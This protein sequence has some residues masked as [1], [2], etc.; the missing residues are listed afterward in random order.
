MLLQTL[1]LPAHRRKSTTSCSDRPPL[2][3]RSRGLGPGRPPFTRSVPQQPTWGHRAEKSNSSSFSGGRLRDHRPAS[4]RLHQPTPRTTGVPAGGLCL[5]PPHPGPAATAPS[6]QAGGRARLWAGSGSPTWTEPQSGW[7]AQCSSRE[8]QQQRSSPSSSR[9]SI[10]PGRADGGAG[11]GRPGEG[12][13]RAGS[14]GVGSHPSPERDCPN[15]NSGGE[16]G[17]EGG[18]EGGGREAGR[19]AG[20]E[21]KG[22][23]GKP[24]AQQV[25]APSAG[26]HASTPALP[27]SLPARP[28]GCPSPGCSAGR[29]RQPARAGGPRPALTAEPGAPSHPGGRVSGRK[30]LEPAAG[31][32]GPGVGVEGLSAAGG[33]RRRE[34]RGSAARGLHLPPARRC[35]CSDF[36]SP[37]RQSFARPA[38]LGSPSPPGLLPAAASLRSAPA[39]LAQGGGGPRVGSGSSGGT[40]RRRTRPPR[41]PRSQGGGE[42]STGTP[43]SWRIFVPVAVK[44]FLCLFV[45]LFTYFPPSDGKALRVTGGSCRVCVPSPVSVRCNK[46]DALWHS[47]FCVITMHVE[48]FNSTCGEEDKEK[49]LISRHHSPASLQRGSRSKSKM[50]S[51]K[52][53][54]KMV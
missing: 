2:V 7:R 17:R 10:P 40:G 19:W 11:S 13:E 53:K 35:C 41:P 36:S 12:A 20:G 49:P 1:W 42:G 33:E 34:R 15:F 24:S 22:W 39:R 23:S 21:G 6:M 30:S 45:Y 26:R 9:S 16:G 14:R 47:C 54:M 4:T 29:R 25:P 52:S 46:E 28:A 48:I 51:R 3:Q 32:E 8:G 44:W 43:V 5:P 38:P 37:S 50:K 18:R 31:T 27:A